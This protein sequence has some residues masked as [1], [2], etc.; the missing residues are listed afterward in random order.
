MSSN[1][2]VECVRQILNCARDRRGATFALSPAPDPAEGTQR[3]QAPPARRS[4]ISAPYETTQERHPPRRVAGSRAHG[5]ARQD[6]ERTAGARGRRGIRRWHCRG[7]PDLPHL[8]GREPAAPREPRLVVVPAGMRAAAGRR[9]APE[10]G[11]PNERLT[12]G[13]EPVTALVPPGNCR[14]GSPAYLK[15]AA[16]LLPTGDPPARSTTSRRNTLVNTRTPSQESPSDSGVVLAN[17]WVR[18]SRREPCR[19]RA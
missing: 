2:I 15:G 12:C 4:R 14:R 16:R 19:H 17:G 3:E 8:L 10:S 7:V 13:S 18:L 1:H 9:E 5:A 11:I 6:E